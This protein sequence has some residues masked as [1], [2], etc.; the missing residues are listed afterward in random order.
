MGGYSSVYRHQLI[1]GA[2]PCS[3]YNCASLLKQDRGAICKAACGIKFETNGFRMTV[4]NK[5]TCVTDRDGCRQH[6]HGQTAAA[7]CGIFRFEQKT[8]IPLCRTAD[9][10]QTKLSINMVAEH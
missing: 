10:H 9:L 8:I 6:F 3:S 1:F 5:P 4:F 2:I 7:F